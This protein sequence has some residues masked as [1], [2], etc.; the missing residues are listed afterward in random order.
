MNL[1][2]IQSFI[3]RAANLRSLAGPV[4]IVMILAM[5]VLPLPPFLLDI[6]FT[7]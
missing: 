1:T 6:L 4:L 2:I 5:M 3:N 7:F